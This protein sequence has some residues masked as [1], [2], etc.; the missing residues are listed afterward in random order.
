MSTG[1]SAHMSQHMPKHMATHVCSVAESQAVDRDVARRLV[2]RGIDG[3]QHAEPHGDVPINQSP[4][5]RTERLKWDFVAERAKMMA[6]KM[7]FSCGEGLK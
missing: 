6:T 5:I 2:H 7:G 4:K 3:N 1:M